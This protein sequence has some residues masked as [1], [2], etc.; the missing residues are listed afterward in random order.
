MFTVILLQEIKRATDPTLSTVL[1]KIREGT[2]D[3]HVSEVL[4]S[5]LQKQDINAV[6][7]DKT[8]IT[9]STRAECDKINEQCLERILGQMCEYES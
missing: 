1:S 8:V 9:C 7:L 5:R 3:S 6:H 4:R 2:C